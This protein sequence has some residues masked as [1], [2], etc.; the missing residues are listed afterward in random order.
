MYLSAH[1]FKNKPTGA[2]EV[3][4]V[5]GNAGTNY[6]ILLSCPPMGEGNDVTYTDLQTGDLLERERERGGGGG[7]LNRAFAV[8]SAFS[9]EGSNVL[10]NESQGV[11]LDISL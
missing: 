1:L 11:R 5:I 7:G 2:H 9:L 6:K 8:Y 3:D 4:F 10:Y